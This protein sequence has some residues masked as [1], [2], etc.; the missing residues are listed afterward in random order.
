[1]KT[2]TRVIAAAIAVYCAGF[3]ACN[4]NDD[5][6][7]VTGSEPKAVETPELLA[8]VCDPPQG[9]LVDNYGSLLRRSMSSAEQC[10]NLEFGNIIQAYGQ[11]RDAFSVTNGETLSLLFLINAFISDTT[12]VTFGANGEYTVLM[13]E[14]K[15]ELQR[16]WQFW[17]PV[18][19]LGQHHSFFGDRT[20]VLNAYSICDQATVGDIEA[21]A[22][23]IIAAYADENSTLRTPIYVMDAYAQIQG[24]N[25][26]IVIGDG[27]IDIMAQVAQVEKGIAWTGILAHEWAHHIQFN[28]VTDQQATPEWTRHN[29]LGADFMAAYFMTHPE[30]SQY[31]WS[32][33]VDFYQ[34]FFQIGDCEFQDAGHHGTPQQRMA[35]ARMGYTIAKTAAA[36]APLSQTEI[37]AL[38]NTLADEI[39]NG[40]P[41]ARTAG[42]SGFTPAQRIAYT[43]VK[44]YSDEIQGIL[45]GT[46]DPKTLAD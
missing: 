10:N 33:E 16:F 45:S 11:Q 46:V 2:K 36:T 7:N 13:Q 18:T 1:M 40:L 17:D 26:S 19:L 43:T 14:R 30:G 12:T 20:A 44:G 9:R 15:K 22:D 29:E 27:M 23:L 34:L 6:N 5:D 24:G 4:K 38:F 35:A 21:Q 31:L 3:V 28:L 32:E 39:I 37:L 25:R 42:L 8:L 41:A